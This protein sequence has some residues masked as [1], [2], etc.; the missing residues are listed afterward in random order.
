M[1]N[2]ESNYVNFIAKIKTLEDSYI[3]FIM[4]HNNAKSDRLDVL[5]ETAATEL[6]NILKEM[7]KSVLLSSNEL[8]IPLY[9][10]TDKNILN[11]ST[12]ERKEMKDT[13]SILLHELLKICRKENINISTICQKLRSKNCSPFQVSRLSNVY[14][15]SECAVNNASLYQ[16]NDIYVTNNLAR[17]WQY[18]KRSYILGEYGDNAYF[19]YN[20]L[21]I[22]GC[23]VDNNIDAKTAQTLD[24]VK[25]A[26]LRK[27]QPIIV[28]ITGI[29]KDCLLSENG[30]HIP[31]FIE[32]IIKAYLDNDYF[33][34]YSFKI[35]DFNDLSS[36]KILPEDYIKAVLSPNEFDFT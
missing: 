4:N 21:Q 22:L 5:L 13:C 28:Q 23:E 26:A 33:S 11:M 7:V 6:K 3:D 17:A 15:R 2:N 27:P 30:K 1:Q 12:D 14:L 35:K 10:G 31:H 36:G 29:D 24:M 18:A 32:H 25:K 20:T 34:A 19:L 16:Y 8:F 9:H